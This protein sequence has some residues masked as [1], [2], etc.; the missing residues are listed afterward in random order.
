[1]RVS[2]LVVAAAMILGVGSASAQQAVDYKGRRIQIAAGD[3]S[4]ECLTLVRKAID[5]TSELPPKQKALA[6]EV[7][8]LRCLPVPEGKATNEVRDNT[9]GVYTMISP[10]DPGGYIRFPMKPGSLSAA[11]VA[12]SLVGN[13]GYARWHHAY[14]AAKQKADTAPPPDI[15]VSSRSPTRMPASRPSASSTRM[16]A[17]PSRPSTWENAAWRPS[18]ARWTCGAVLKPGPIRSRP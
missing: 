13:G 7:K 18:D 5:M 12:L 8:D 17:P 1:M 15:S 2:G 3:Q 9:V 6:A 16:I 10:D 4:A 14:L 11:D